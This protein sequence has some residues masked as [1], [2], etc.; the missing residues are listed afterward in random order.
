[1]FLALLLLAMAAPI[2]WVAASVPAERYVV[3]FNDDAVT[4][5]YDGPLTGT[6]ASFLQL[7]SAHPQPAAEAAAGESD[8]IGDRRVDPDRVV[9]HVRD[10]A[11]RNRVNTIEDVY[12]SAV[13]G[14]SA[15]LTATQSAAIA[16][17]P[18]VASVV[19]DEE[20]SIDGVDDV[21]LGGSIRTTSNPPDRVQPGIRRIGA[22]TSTVTSLIAGGL[23]V[24]AD[25][26]VLDTGIQRDHP[27]L[28]VVGGYNCTGRD[29][30]KWD[31]NEGHGTHV[32]GIVG[33]LDNRIGVTGVAPGVRLWSV[34]VLD[35]NGHGFVSWLICGI[36]W[37]TAQRDRSNSS[38]PLIEVANMSLAF[39]LPGG[40]DAAC[41]TVNHDA[42]H[43]AI[44]RSVD[45]G[46]VYVAAA[47]NDSKNVR[48]VRP[49]AYDE[50]ITVS[51]M[52]DYDGRGGG[53]GVPSD[54]CPYWSPEPDDAFTS[55]SNYG[56][57]V[58]LIAP[59]K[60]IL[61]TYLR[62][63]YAW[64]SGTSMATPH[65]AGAAVIYRTMFPKA[66]PNQVRMALEAV[67][68]LDWK[69]NTDPDKVHEKAVWI[70]AFRAVPDFSMDVSL[71]SGVV[72]PGA[73]LPV[74]V[75]LL[76]VGGFNDALTV[77]LLNPPKG[78]SATPIV[79][80]GS[81]ASLNVH[82][83]NGMRLGR[84]TVTV[85]AA[86]HGI[87]H[88]QTFTVVV[89]GSA[90]QASF[91]SPRSNLTIQSA[92]TVSVAWKER[93]GGASITGRKLERQSAAI[94]TPG[95]C[96]GVSYSTE[97]TRSNASA[98]TDHVRAGRCYR[99]VLTVTN[100]SGYRSTVYSGAVLV[101]TTAPAA[102]KVTAAGEVAARPNLNALG[103]DQTYVTKDG[104]VWVRG[105]TAG[106]VPI[107][108][109]ATDPESG[110]ARN[111]VNINGAGWRAAWIGVS[112]DGSLRLSYGSGASSAQLA[113][114]SVNGAGMRSPQATLTLM[115]DSSSPAAATWVSAPTGTTKHIRGSYFKLRWSS[116]SDSGSGLAA[117]QVVARYR[118]PLTSSGTCTRNGFSA[119]TGF[120]LASNASWASGL[121]A[122]SCY[123]WSI[124][125]VDNVGNT[126]AY[127]VS[128]Y[129]ITDRR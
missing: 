69:T 60:C 129:V 86:A 87:Q 51:A 20:I 82:V 68:T 111:V 99:W 12:S 22:R 88:S 109:R 9:R 11:S 62:G 38:R 16:A 104:V 76:R 128:G 100:S 2:G 71:S 14:F 123:V 54:S 122:H 35:K 96:D 42:V 120:R 43:M 3:L 115:P 31:D 53:K 113:L 8:G 84:Y 83:A 5:P 44:C 118:A 98:T 30:N 75:S 24:N 1:M 126:S 90:P 15:R 72:P 37:V 63:R 80:K 112:G 74:D 119:D 48:T 95:T 105:G 92:S 65:V 61:S 73:T 58:D 94:R 27:D 78:I 85:S 59:G 81:T 28:N 17:D 47:G 107:Q 45:K 49:A 50:V 36:D 18:S 33:A 39:R 56:P 10:V 108:V 23:K 116:A 125:T 110:I 29:R 77:S 46:T 57:D 103:V 25:V 19:P 124:R 64:M 40:N 97:Q 101:D 70:G 127:V 102:P 4:V 114:S 117:Q 7:A 52:A 66:S 91:T 79:T 106:S 67:G 32:A 26:A 55:F 41:G 21:G 13:G 93:S 34:K 6:T 121:E 89:R